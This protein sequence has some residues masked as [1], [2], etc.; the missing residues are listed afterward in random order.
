MPITA[1]ENPVLIPRPLSSKAITITWATGD[2]TLGRVFEVRGTAEV[3]FDDGGSA[4]GARSGSK[5]R[6][7]TVGETVLFRLRRAAASSTI[8]ATLTVTAQRAVSILDVI[9]ASPVGVN[10]LGSFQFIYDLRVLPGLDYVD[11]S[12]RTSQPTVP[13]VNLTLDA[14]DPPP[15]TAVTFAFPLFKGMQTE[16][17]IRVGNPPRL[18]QD[19]TYFY[20][21]IATGTGRRGDAVVRGTFTTGSQDAELFF[22][23]IHVRRDGDPNS[24]GDFTFYF[25]A[26][27]AETKDELGLPWPTYS[28]DISDGHSVLVGRSIHIPRAPRRLWVGVVGVDDDSYIF[29]PLCTLGHRPAPTGPRTDHAEQE[30]CEQAWVWDEF[31]TFENGEFKSGLRNYPFTLSTG[32]FGVAFDVS[33]GLRVSAVAGASFQMRMPKGAVSPVATLREPGRGAAIAMGRDG[34][35]MAALGPDGAIYYKPISVQRPALPRGQWMRLDGPIGGAVTVVAS[36]SGA[37]NFFA[38]GR[39]GGVLHTRCAEDGE[40]G[41]EW[42]N[43]GGAPLGPV[44]ADVSPQGQVELFIVGEEGMVLHR[45]WEEETT[46]GYTDW[47]SL[48]GPVRGSLAPL[49][50][51]GGGLG[52]F[53]LGCDG[54][55]LH[56]R[57]RG[58]EWTDAGAWDSLGGS[59]A[60]E[61]GVTRQDDGALLVF[62]VTEDRRIFVKTWAGYP[63]TPP[64]EPW[65]EAGTIDSLFER[66]MVRLSTEAA[67]ATLE[68]AA[69]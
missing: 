12:F 14:P 8:L 46:Q 63:D 33:G 39:E 62:V 3:L 55:V 44:A 37:A 4:G 56:K 36:R 16:H 24:A 48:G 27:D 32:N 19:T 20:K 13:L 30:A 61:L 65:E 31:D 45:S 26:G 59:F 29:A 5:Q 54:S 1:S 18:E 49:S 17:E 34:V 15:G 38:V 47:K 42:D 58:R 23:R 64:P 25:G 40:P 2:S 50:L 10:I 68:A 43:L 21:I 51:P 60:G 41:R 53:A 6:T 7:F 66:Q 67:P 57:R 11:F 52:L 35:L 69:G 22:D 9:G 28:A